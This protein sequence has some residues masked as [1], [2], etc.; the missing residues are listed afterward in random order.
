MLEKTLESKC[1]DLV[2]AAGGRLPKWVAPGWNGVTD[3]ILFMP[4]RTPVFVEFKKPGANL[5]L[6][7]QQKRWRLWLIRNGFLHWKIDD[8]DDFIARLKEVADGPKTPT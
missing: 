5:K 3:R 4:F 6:R 7:Q 1:F 8:L 2:K